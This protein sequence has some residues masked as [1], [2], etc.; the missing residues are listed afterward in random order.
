MNLKFLVKSLIHNILH[1]SRTE[2]DT[3]IKLRP[4]TK[5]IGHIWPGSRKPLIDLR[6]LIVDVVFQFL[7]LI[8]ETSGCPISEEYHIIHS[9]PNVAPM[10][11]ICSSKIENRTQKY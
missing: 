6:K 2:F 11:T 3:D 8:S 1:N 7:C 9:I 4:N 10:R 5:Q